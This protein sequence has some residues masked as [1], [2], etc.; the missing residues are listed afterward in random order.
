MPVLF[1]TVVIDLIGFGIM[2][3]ILPFLAPQLGGNDFD[4]A[5][6]ILIYSLFAGLCGPF[7][8]KLSDRFGRKPIILCCLGG[9]AISY[10]LLAYSES[11]AAV[12]ASRA[13]CGIMAGNFG[14][15]SAMIADM[16]TAEN[17]AKGMGLIGAAFGM[18][19]VI[20]PFLG[21]VLAGDDMSFARPSLAAAALSLLAMIAGAITLKESLPKN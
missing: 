3:P 4:I 16:T 11:L 1:L 17:R 6:I 8:G 12:Y 21:G 20:G 15:A 14:V 2:M 9:T 7:W 19:M 10:L 18:G 5:M 13:F